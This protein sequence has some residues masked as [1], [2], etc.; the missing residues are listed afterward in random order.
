MIQDLLYAIRIVLKNPGFSAVV[1]M[2][3]AL[4]IGA[5]AALFSIVN[6]VLLNPLPFPEPDQ[7][8]TIHQSK[9]NFDAGAI[10]YP[11]FLD[12]QRD[13]QTL[14]SIAISRGGAFTLIGQGEAERVNARMISADYF[15]VYGTKPALGRT[16]T[17]DD[18][19]RGAELVTLISEPLWTR[20]FNSAPDIIT[21]SIT[22]DDKSY[23]VV[24]VIPSSFILL[25]STDV[26]V[27]IGA[28]DAPPLQS[29]SAA[30]GIH[31][32]GRLK[33]GVTFDQAQADLSRVMENLAI[34]YPATNKGQGA[35]LI[36]LKE[37]LVGDVKPVLLMLLSAVGFVLLIACVNVSNLMLARST[38][39]TREFA[40]RAALGAGRWRLL[41]QSLIESTLFS[42]IGGAA[43]LFIAAWATK[44]AL[45]A[46]P[47]ALPRAAEVGLDARVLAFTA[48]VALLTGVLSGL[49]PALRT[50]H[51]RFNESLKEGGRGASL[52]RARAQGLFVAVEMA[53]ALVL[54]IGAG[55]L[56]RSLNAL[57]KVDP[58]FRPDNVVT[59][60]VTFAPSMLSASANA[61]RSSLRELSN[62][63]TTIPGVSAAS[64]SFGAA[65]LISEDDMYFWVDGEPK[66][67]SN[68]EMHMAL[69]YVVEPGYLQALGLQLKSGRFF[70]DHD[71]ER[72]SR[73][74]VVDEMLARQRFGMENPIGKRIN[75]EDNQG[76]YEI[77][78]VV[79][80]VKQ[81]SLDS[82][83]TRS[84]QAQLYLP[85]RALPDDQISGTG[86]VGV[87]VRANDGSGN[88]GPA[89]FG[90]IR[91]AIQSHN[92]QN[93]ISNAQTMNEVIADSLARR[94]FSMII[95]GSFA[96]AA[97]LLA[98][99][100]IYGVISY[101]VGQRTHEL[102][103]R[104]ALGAK[105]IDILRL[106]LGHGM[107]MTIVGIGI[108]LLSALGLTRLIKAMLFGVSPADPVTFIGIS[109][110]LALVAFLACYIPARRATKVDP[111]VALRYE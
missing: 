55:L 14:S 24:G 91:N 108:G 66:P 86:G 28:W 44:A 49:A 26:Y 11:N 65:P 10:P 39:R 9:P 16:F 73:V 18:D 41:R 50:S 5:N 84:L 51:S 102:G 90:S 54:L 83:H 61:T 82:D 105:R 62:K 69:F 81:W 46:L 74:V 70:N 6:G 32:I 34:A 94:R 87:V 111:L 60:G 110:L 29:R 96:A 27:P 57:W 99:L 59:F 106:V 17:A 98:T 4:G 72:S 71:D 88:P 22:L 104:V 75:L 97:L 56:L 7:L 80:H 42:L 52:V 30:M 67:T 64:L 8:V 85:F 68:S 93:V 2:T 13:N 92:N 77:I 40:I 12:M 36:R 103:I 109:L 45:K 76:P 19:R 21:K 100:G 47:S 25:G 107:K 37:R 38:G 20:K 33:P 53:M 23:R 63:L 78:G 89:F 95:L 35:K 43:G 101:L 79:G 31:G 48:G 15:K 3:L 1:V 58:G